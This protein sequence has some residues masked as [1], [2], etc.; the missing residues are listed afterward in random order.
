MARTL[1]S[2]AGSE[3]VAWRKTHLHRTWE[4]SHCRSRKRMLHPTGQAEGQQKQ[5]EESD[6]LI[7]LGVRESR[8]HGE[9]KGQFPAT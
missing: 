8:I 6:S 5:C 9:A 7:V 1:E 3:T 4:T 2:P